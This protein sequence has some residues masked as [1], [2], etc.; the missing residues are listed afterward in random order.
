[1]MRALLVVL[2]LA[3]TAD[4]R[5][6]PVLEL[7]FGGGALTGDNDVDI[8]RTRH[9][10]VGSSLRLAKPLD[11]VV[12]A[13]AFGGNYSPE[14]DLEQS[15]LAFHAGFRWFPYGRIPD[16]PRY[17]D[18]LRSIYLQATAGIAIL[19]LIPYN[20]L[21]DSQDPEAVG[22]VGSGALGWL[23]VRV[24]GLSFGAEVRDDVIY[25]SSDQGLRQA[26]A[27]Y[28]WIQIDFD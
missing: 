21:F 6:P 20:E 27:L 25:F 22:V 5:K 8:T 13:E 10:L 1:M 16:G 15:V 12:T 24:R 17:G 3:G 18:N 7:G 4:A 9:I 14:P 23:P 26:I 11:L 19:T 28:G 2:V